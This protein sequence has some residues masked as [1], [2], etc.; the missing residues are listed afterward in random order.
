MRPVVSNA[1]AV[2]LLHACWSS[3]ATAPTAAEPL[4]ADEALA[5]GR[6]TLDKATDHLQATGLSCSACLW[7]QKALRAALDERSPKRVKGASK[8]RALAS[9]AMW[10]TGEASPCAPRRFPKIPVIVGNT[11]ETLLH[12]EKAA[13]RVYADF[14]EVKGGKKAPLKS[15]H[16]AVAETQKE[17][18]KDLL[19]ICA[20]LVEA[21]GEQVVA[22]VAAQRGRAYAALSERWLCSRVARLCP[23]ERTRAESG[24]DDEQDSE[25]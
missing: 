9:A 8:R 10:A 5:R 16:F 14:D 11:T 19:A 20:A 23:I 24:D 22:R 12:Q 1:F 13:Q 15:E 3:A 17:A 21:F 2:A 25:L 7:A 4:E 18:R 6:A